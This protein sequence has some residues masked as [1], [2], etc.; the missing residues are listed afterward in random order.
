MTA[1]ASAR[2][3]APA[4]F[5]P[6]PQRRVMIAKLHVAKKQLNMAD[7]DYREFLER[8]TG[9]R[10]AADLSHGELA[11]ALAEM[12]RLG[13]TE[14]P[15][16][17][18]PAGK[19]SF[20]PAASKARAMLISLGLM[21]V[22]R[23]SSEKALEAFARRQ[24]G[25]DKLAWADQ[26]QV[27]KLIEALKAIANRNGWNQSTEGLADPVWTLKLRLCEAIID[28]LIDAG[29]V[30]VGTALGELAAEVLHDDDSLSR[31]V[32]MLTERQLETIAAAL[33]ARLKAGAKP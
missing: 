5:A 27:Y 7:D 17:A 20:T 10:S 12:K 4:Q 8:G 6:D 1:A 9:K 24:L 14:A 32:M 3:A 21:G 26:A 15:K 30:P 31:P 33:G 23:D 18:R 22:I 16:S 28:R 2:R 11:A 25:V 13:F 29:I 19:G